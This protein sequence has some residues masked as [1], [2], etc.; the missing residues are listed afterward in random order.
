MKLIPLTQ[1][2]NAIVDD[3]D[4]E[5]VM[6]HKW[7]YNKSSTNYGLAKS[8]G[9]RMHRFIVG[10]PKGTVIDHINNNP[11]DNR[12]SNLRVTTQANNQKNMSKHR[13]NKSGYKGVSWHSKTKK[14]QAHIR[15]EGKNIYLG[16]FAD[17]KQAAK[18]YNIKALEHFGEYANINCS[19]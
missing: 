11:L 4:Y 12:R 9:I 1:G 10:A 13:D 15:V 5:V 7:H 18:A 2:K 16:L 14:W 8:N 6:K 19:L 3:A 17:K